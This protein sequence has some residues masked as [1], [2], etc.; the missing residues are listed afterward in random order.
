MPIYV[1]FSSSGGKGFLKTWDSRVLGVSQGPKTLRPSNID[2]VHSYAYEVQSPRDSATGQAAGKR[3]HEPI[4]ITKETDAS[5]P[6]L[7]RLASNH[8]VL[9]TLNINFEQVDSKGLK[10]PYLAIN[11]TNATIVGVKRK[12]NPGKAIATNVHELEEISFTFQKI[13]IVYKNSKTSMH[14]DWAAGD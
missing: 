14:D 7:F 8:E 4:T 11:L 1:N 3:Q 12:P 5:S 2:T 9:G 10:Q 6:S 13:V